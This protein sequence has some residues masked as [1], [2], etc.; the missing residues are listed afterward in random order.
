MPRVRCPQRR[1]VFWEDDYCTAEEIELDPEQ[2][3][4]L[5]MEELEDEVVEDEEIWDDEDLLED[6][7]EWFDEDEE[8]EEGWPEEEDELD[9]FRMR[10]RDEDDW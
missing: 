2:L 1:C 4:C 8:D 6:E 3:S 5:T 9:S 7:D 10:D